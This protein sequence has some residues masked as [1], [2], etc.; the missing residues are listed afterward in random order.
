MSSQVRVKAF[1][2]DTFGKSA[3]KVV[4]ESESLLDSGLIDS[5]GIYELVSFVES[6]FD[7]R[8]NDE[9][10][11]PENFESIESIARFV[12]AKRDG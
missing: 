9:E 7:V 4:G 11:V 2:D 10:I 12:D 3:G 8:V 6:E 1:V 5:T